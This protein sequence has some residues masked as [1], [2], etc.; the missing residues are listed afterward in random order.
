MQTPRRFLPSLSLLSAFEAASRTGS[1]TA[2]ARELALTQS[3]VSRQIKALEDQ[4]EVE[5]FHRE[6]QT[7]RLTAAGDI[8][9]R[10]I[11]DALRKIS[12]ASL[13]LRANPFGGTLN[14]AILPT[15][16]TRWLAPRL[17]K[18]LARNPG[19]TINL[20]TRL[21]QFDFRLEAVDA[22][23][24]FGPAEWPGGALALLRSET[25]VPAC[26][27]DLRDRFRFETAADIR[28]APLLHLT[29]RPDAWERWLAAHDVPAHAVHGMLFDQFATAAQ[30]A[31]AGLGVA[32]LPEFLVE[33]ELRSG[34]LV[35][36]LDLP[37]TSAEAYY[38]AWPHDRAN[39]PPLIAFR[40]WLLAET[41]ADR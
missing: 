23:I 27:P 25:V 37:M 16:G 38:L 19:I 34:Q 29:S 9:A 31:I 20:V 10:E 33:E 3:A 30:A 32:L 41:Q 12:T 4:L 22:A 14:L 6:R 5:L 2:A 15:F 1:I 28:M 36:A 18:F 7:I 17:P 40:E 35:R 39:H 8:Y 24:H 21:T 13:N 11:R 26:S